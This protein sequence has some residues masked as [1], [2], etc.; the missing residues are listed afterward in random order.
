MVVGLT[1]GLSLA[2]RSIVGLRTAEEDIASQK[3]LSAAEA[4]IEQVSKTSTSIA[5][6]TF[7]NNTTY[8]ATIESVEGNNFLLN[9][10]N[11][12]LKNDGADIW[13]SDYST[14]PAELYN[15]PWSGSLN[16]YWG[17]SSD[18]CSQAA[19]EIIVISGSK[20][21]PISTKHAFD[22]CVPRSN[23]NSFST[24]SAGGII[25]GK[26]FPFSATFNVT[27]GILARV[28]PLYNETP[29]GVAGSSA[30]PSQGSFITSTGVSGDITRKVT[31]FQGFPTL[32]VEYFPYGIFVP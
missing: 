5:N 17:Q 26:N 14:D 28:I 29:I 32:P 30:L 8:N 9:G 2:S 18:G 16:I 4:G 10:G 15:N 21:N 23:S 11:S 22:P 19:L 20:A 25:N 31:L 6:G 24:V 12:V 1:V 3:A 7:S 13:L 27:N